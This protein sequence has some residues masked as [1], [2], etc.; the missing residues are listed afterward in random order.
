MLKNDE[1]L[2]AVPSSTVSE[3]FFCFWK[4]PEEGKKSWDES[5][6]AHV[7]WGWVG[8]LHHSSETGW[9]KRGAILSPSELSHASNVRKENMKGSSDKIK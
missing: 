8:A 1:V 3:V 5:S 4:R 2:C 7:Q 9:V 6:G